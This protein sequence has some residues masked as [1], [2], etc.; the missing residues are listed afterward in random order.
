MDDNVKTIIPIK[1]FSHSLTTKAKE[2]NKTQ[3]NFRANEEQTIKHTHHCNLRSLRVHRVEVSDGVPFHG[4]DAL[5]Q[6][7]LR[8]ERGPNENQVA[9]PDV[10]E[11]RGEVVG[12]EDVA[13][14]V[15]GGEHANPIRLQAANH[16]IESKGYPKS[17]KRSRKA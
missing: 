7:D 3:I 14:Y 5:R 2:K 6:P 16:A 1:L 17:T 11:Q 13:G 8:V 9:V 10:P 12:E 15:E 4:H